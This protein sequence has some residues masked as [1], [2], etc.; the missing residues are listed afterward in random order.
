MEYLG[1]F[2]VDLKDTPFANYSPQDWVFEYLFRFSHI[3]GSH[4]KQWVLDQI[5]RI[6]KGTKV[7]VKVSK[8]SNGHQEYRFFLD[9]PSQEYLDWVTLYRREF[10]QK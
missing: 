6:L 2:D 1:E 3:D 7:I 10:D 8:W 5:A 9:A 4:H